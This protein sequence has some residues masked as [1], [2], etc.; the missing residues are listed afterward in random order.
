MGEVYLAEDTILKRQVAIKFLAQRLLG[1]A[2][3]EKRFLR[4]AHIIASLDHPN[5]CGIY[6]IGE[7]AGRSFAVI[8][9][10]EGE[11]LDARMSRQALTLNEVLSIASQIAEALAEAHEHD[12]IHR[13]IKPQNII[14]T[15]NGQVKVLDFGLSKLIQDVSDPEAKTLSIVSE[16]GMVIGTIPYM[17]PEQVR[18]E[19]VDARSDLFSFGCLVY[20]M[21]TGQQPF[22]R[23]SGSVATISAILSY[24]PP[25]LSTYEPE[26]PLVLQNVVTRCLAKSKDDRYQSASDLLTDLRRATRPESQLVMQAS[27]WLDSLRHNTLARRRM[28]KI[29]LAVA[30]VILIGVVL[31]AINYRS[32]RSPPTPSSTADTLGTKTISSIAVLPFIADAVAP[33]SEYLSDGLTESL[34]SDLSLVPNVKVIARS[35]VFRYKNREVD[36]Q[37][38]GRELDVQA[39][40]MGHIKFRGDELLVMAELVNALDNSLIW[41]GQYPQKIQNLLEVEN[42]ISRAIITKLE[43]NVSGHDRADPKPQ[44]T[45][46]VEAY[47]LYL[48]GRY[49]LNKRT[50]PKEAAQYFQQAI[51]RDPAYPQAYAGL[52]DAYTA[53]GLN[54]Y[55]GFPPLEAMPRAKAAAVKAIELED[56]LAEAHVSLA[57]IRMQYDW[58]WQGAE[59]EFKRAIALNPNYAPAYQWFVLYHLI[60]NRF[61][62]AL[63]DAKKAQE[64]DPLSLILYTNIGRT[65]YYSRKYDEA[66]AQLKSALDID[67]HSLSASILLGL[68]YENKKMYKEAI[69]IYKSTLPLTNNAPWSTAALAHAYAASGKRAEAMKIIQQLKSQSEKT[70]ISPF[71]IGAI[72]NGLGDRDQAF[73]WFE[74]AY[75]DHSGLLIY[76]KIEPEFDVLRSDARYGDLMRRIGLG[77]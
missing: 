43:S 77:S 75:R 38:V 19:P 37:T 71:H 62:E 27:M 8:Q 7:D 59:N 64:L 44:S 48:K 72:Y 28:R 5:I 30:G 29:A 58:D 25:P 11:T 2:R 56:S 41:A 40:V 4:E 65:L 67:K 47:D 74:K 1:D 14:I 10:V 24:D 68:C 57:L 18:G 31:Y 61:D 46:D 60:M 21:V 22:A 15:R 39:V 51:D 53:L 23:T 55:E 13:D 36:A 73:E 63:A 69:E 26:T 52:A 3:A 12:V 54:L 32:R 50:N 6:E 45:Q 49:S 9:Y 34:M 20:E 66:I 35:S 70:Y 17:S 33:D 16:A 76:L 42:G